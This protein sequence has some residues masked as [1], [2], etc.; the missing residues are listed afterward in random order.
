MLP[1][2]SFRL[3][4][5]P[6]RHPEFGGSRRHASGLHQPGRNL[7]PE[8]LPGQSDYGRSSRGSS[9]VDLEPAEL[10]PARGVDPG[11]PRLAAEAAVENGASRLT[12]PTVHVSRLPEQLQWRAIQQA[13]LYSPSTTFLA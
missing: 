3:Q 13:V 4:A 9:G 11:L 12:A 8:E 10:A 2:A 6:G 1:H 7:A 5:L